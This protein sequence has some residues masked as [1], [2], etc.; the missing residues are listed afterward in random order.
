MADDVLYS[1]LSDYQQAILHGLEY[2]QRVQ[3][4]VDH[5][6]DKRYGGLDFLHE[7]WTMA[8][9][10]LIY[11]F[12]PQFIKGTFVEAASEHHLRVNFPEYLGDIKLLSH[13]SVCLDQVRF[14][15]PQTSQAL[16]AKAF[17]PLQ[18][19]VSEI[20][21]EGL[22]LL[23]GKPKKGKSYLA[24][25]MSLAIAVGRL[26][27]RHFPTQQ[28]RVLYV[29]LEDGERRLQSRLLKIQPNLTTPD[30]LDFL[31]TFPRLGEGAIEALEHYSHTYDV[32]IID[33][34]GRI[35]PTVST[36]RKNINEYNEFTELFGQI[37]TLANTNK[38]AVVLIDHVRKAG[39]EDVYDTIMGSQGKWGTADIGLVYERKGEEKDAVLHVAG[40]DVEEQKFVLSLMD[41]HLEFLGKGEAYE[42]DSEQNRII[43]VLEEERRALSTVEI[44]KAMGIHEQHYA[45]FRKVLQRMYDGDRI[46]RTKRG[47]WT[48][49][50]H[51]RTYTP[52]VDERRWNDN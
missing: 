7:P 52:D 40:R 29:S 38:T 17:D 2:K 15:Q 35:L 48:L 25:D 21:H 9:L 10:A 42:L 43:K 49:Y 33:V 1:S 37:Q 27:F 16:L 34:I 44:M 3:A 51:D 12:S 31:Y 24:L 6:A 46:G 32:I 22:T 30:G 13:N 18:Y 19:I 28:R 8:Q 14:P 39:A 26:A 20:L 45:R 23:A 47:S 5:A 41:G 11:H 36:V 50:G 4:L